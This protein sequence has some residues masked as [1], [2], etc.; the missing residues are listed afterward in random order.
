MTTPATPAAAVP[1]LR[2]PA[3]LTSRL[4]VMMFLQY[5]IWGAWTTGLADYLVKTLHF[6]GHPHSA[7]PSR[8]IMR[9]LDCRLRPAHRSTRISKSQLENRKFSCYGVTARL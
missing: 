4:S 9:V 8:T 5:A 7:K 3:L 6:T 2:S 1:G